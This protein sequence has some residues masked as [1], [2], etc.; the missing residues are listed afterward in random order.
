MKVGDV[1][2]Q[3][4]ISVAPDTSI[5]DAAKLMLKERVSGLPVITSAG[6]L[7]GIVT[8]G[9][10]LRRTEIGTEKHRPHWLEFI[11][12]QGRLANE[13]VHSHARAVFD[14]MTR[15]VVV[16]T[17]D[18]PLDVAVELMER[19][20][21]KR[22]PV[23]RDGKVVGILARAN[24]LHALAAGPPR[25]AGHNDDEA[26]RRALEQEIER[27]PWNARQFHF[28]VKDGAIDLWGFI[29]SEQQR[30][31]IRVA[32]ENIPGVKRVRDQML[33][34]EPYTG[35]VVSAV[36]DDRPDGPR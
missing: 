29:T 9:D 22:L 5:A 33:W 27:Q 32:A 23:V 4:V 26:I 18:M 15:D 2:T 19:K 7:L 1:M 34:F 28:V 16:T 13:Y 17:E 8:E 12:S 36:P 6:V 3:E 24:L 10:F 30:T 25:A 21:V 35:M 11:L 20:H 31:A 14:V